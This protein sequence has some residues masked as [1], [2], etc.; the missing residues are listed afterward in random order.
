MLQKVLVTPIIGLPQI[1]GWAQVTQSQDGSFIASFSI[2]GAQAGNV[3]R[4]LVD[5]ISNATPDQSTAVYALMKKIVRFVEDKDCQIQI[6]AC[7]LQNG[8][9]IF[10]TY[11]GALL[12]RRGEKMGTVLRSENELKLIE[13]HRQNGDLFIL[14]TEAALPFKEEIFIKLQQGLD[15]DTAVAS[16]VPGV[17]NLADSS[18]VAMAFIAERL[19]PV[20]E[21]SAKPVIEFSRG[22]IDDAQTMDSPAVLGSPL[23]EILAD[24]KLTKRILVDPR[25][26][27][28]LAKLILNWLKQLMRWLLSGGWRLGRFFRQTFSRQVFVDE[29]DR[30]ANKRLRIGLIVVGAMLFLAIIVG[31]SK[32][33]AG[34]QVK[35]AVAVLANDLANYESAKQLVE[36]QPIQAR[37]LLASVIGNLEAREKAFSQKKS[38]QKYINAKLTEIKTYYD[39]VSGKQVFKD[40]PVYYDFQLIDSKLIANQAKFFGQMGYFIDRDNKKVLQLEISNQKATTIDL[41]SLSKVIDVAVDE[42]NLYILGEGIVEKPISTAGEATEVIAKGKSNQ[43]AKF[44]SAFGGNLYVFNPEQRN[45]FK[46]IYDPATKKFT[47]PIRWVKSAKDL[48]FESVVSM[49]VDGEIWVSTKTGQVFRMVSGESSLFKVN[50]LVEPIN[51]AV[52]LSTAEDFNRLYLLEPGQSR[53]IIVSKQGEFIKEVKSASFASANALIPLEVQNKVFVVSG[54]LVFAVGL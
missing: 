41:A 39:S 52:Y 25:K 16:T 9:I 44:I 34:A 32:L 46:Y 40:L 11:D 20:V 10:A 7:Y 18:L 49:I 37:E 29:Q 3:G 47:E 22:E 43:G 8:E 38:G 27:Q 13:G 19:V 26:V 35:E 24:D 51:S 30:V 54:S 14:M 15:A 17:Q 53:L 36:T 6:S 1:N 42:K 5:L 33:A 4:D 21:D 48:D 2:R 23:I 28:Q 31:L 50:G 12:L 45:I